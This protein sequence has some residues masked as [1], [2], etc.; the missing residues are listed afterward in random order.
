MSNPQQTSPP[1][2]PS[3]SHE[4]TDHPSGLTPIPGAEQVDRLADSSSQLGDEDGTDGRAGWE[5]G[6]EVPRGEGWRLVSGLQA[7]VRELASGADKHATERDSFSRELE[8]LTK[9]TE[10][11]EV[12]RA[13]AA[14]AGAAAEAAASDALQMATDAQRA[15]QASMKEQQRANERTA[16]AET[17]AQNAE[18]EKE[19][20]LATLEALRGTCELLV[21]ARD[22]AIADAVWQHSRAKVDAACLRAVAGEIEDG[23]QACRIGAIGQAQE[24]LLLEGSLVMELLHIEAVAKRVQRTADQNA[25]DLRNHVQELEQLLNEQEFAQ[26]HVRREAEAA[27]EEVIRHAEHRRSTAERSL[28]AAEV[29]CRALTQQVSMLT[30][31]SGQ[32]SNERNEARVE[33]D[34]SLRL[35]DEL[36]GVASVAEA[37]ISELRQVP[38][39]ITPTHST[40]TRSLHPLQPTRHYPAPPHPTTQRSSPHRNSAHHTAQ[41]HTPPYHTIPHHA[42]R[43]AGMRNQTSS[44]CD[45]STL[46]S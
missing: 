43:R 13:A 10:R 31:T 23:A 21:T 22:G 17:C 14:E 27:T 5:S 42:G 26:L 20:V 24:G 7:R 15:A 12:E 3:S 8:A 41:H 45:R 11:L 46:H 4:S 39:P 34:D 35:V 44:R 30:E 9:Q 18:R 28:V 33:L 36:R 38:N 37:S 29:R 16:A 6:G 1:D 40:Y 2:S 25:S 19:H 32:M